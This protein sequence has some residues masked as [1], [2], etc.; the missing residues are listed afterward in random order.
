M[1]RRGPNVS[2]MRRAMSVGST[3]ESAG[4]RY[5]IP[6]DAK[7]STSLVNAAFMTSGHPATMGQLAL[8]IVSTTQLFTCVSIGKKMSL[9]GRFSV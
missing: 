7:K 8:S 5:S 2:N 9:S 6:R 1:P 4:S 3:N